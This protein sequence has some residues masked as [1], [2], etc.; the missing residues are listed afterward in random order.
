M[1]LEQIEMRELKK[2]YNIFKLKRYIKNS[3]CRFN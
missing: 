1:T 2:D 3:Y